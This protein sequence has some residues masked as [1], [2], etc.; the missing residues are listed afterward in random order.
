MLKT[1]FFNL[2]QNGRSVYL[3]ANFKR[4]NSRRAVDE[5]KE[6]VTSIKFSTKTK[7]IFLFLFNGAAVL[8]SGSAGTKLFGEI[9]PENSILDGS[10]R[11]L[12]GVRMQLYFFDVYHFCCSRFEMRLIR[13]PLTSLRP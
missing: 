11:F 8:L 12:P 1:L 6:F 10:S 7:M 5:T 9:F 4:T 3:K 2:D 13:S